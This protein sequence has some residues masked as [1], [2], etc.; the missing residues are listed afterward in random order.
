MD[1]EHDASNSSFGVFKPLGCVVI[2][3]ADAQ[4]ADA[5][6]TALNQLGVHGEDQVCRYTDREML[7]QIDRDMKRA[8]PLA[9]IGQEMN[10]IKAH[11]ELAL[12]GYHWLV[13]RVAD[14]QQAAAVATC[15]RPYGAE[16]AQHY[17]RFIIEELIEHRGDLPQ[18]S[19]S[20]DRGL[21]TPLPDG[22]SPADAIAAERKP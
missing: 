18:V 2:S 15:V 16:R 10:L 8:S 17:G 4:G 7:A 3:F 21:D 14:D 12:R 6:E 1:L 20:P 13:V 19:E 22:S 9:S 11:R 5:A